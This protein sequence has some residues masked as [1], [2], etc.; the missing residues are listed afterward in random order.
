MLTEKKFLNPRRYASKFQISHP[1]RRLDLF[2]ST[3]EIEESQNNCFRTATSF[4]FLPGSVPVP[5]F[6][7]AATTSVAGCRASFFPQ[8]HFQHA[9]QRRNVIA[10]NPTNPFGRE[11][12]VTQHVQRRQDTYI[13]LSLSPPPFIHMTQ[14]L[15]AQSPTS[16]V[17]TPHHQHK[18]HI[19]TSPKSDSGVCCVCVFRLRRKR[20]RHA[21]S[22]QWTLRDDKNAAMRGSRH[23]SMFV[24]LNPFPACTGESPTRWLSA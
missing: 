12:P 23:D 17:V 5:C 8:C 21:R 16:H 19:A 22:P 4:R 6:A 2:V 11:R 14:R 9:K 7:A 3:L 24:A 18:T 13:S 10:R 1:L 20:K 15:S